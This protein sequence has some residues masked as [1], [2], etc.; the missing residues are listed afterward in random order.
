MPISAV[1]S[2]AF[3]G[4]AIYF[5]TNTALLI[6]LASAAGLNVAVI[7][8]T[9][10]TLL[11]INSE[12]LDMVKSGSLLKRDDEKER[13][14]DP[15]VDVKERRAVELLRKWQQLHTVRMVFGG[16]AWGATLGAIIIR[17]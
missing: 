6:L 17:D 4:T 1:I 14:G 3:L 9:V 8:F 15:I 12:L 13:L 5:T 10:A 2:S 7:P 11:P 16:L